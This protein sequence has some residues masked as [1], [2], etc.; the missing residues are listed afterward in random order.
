MTPSAASPEPSKKAVAAQRLSRKVGRIE[1][2]AERKRALDRATAEFLRESALF[3]RSATTPTIFTEPPSPVVLDTIQVR[4][5]VTW[6]ATER[7]RHSPKTPGSR[8]WMPAPS[9]KTPT[10]WTPKAPAACPVAVPLSPLMP[11]TA[12]PA[13][14]SRVLG[15]LPIPGVPLKALPLAI[16][17]LP[18][19]LIV[20][21]YQRSRPAP[22]AC[23]PRLFCIPSPPASAS[24]GPVRLVA[25][26]V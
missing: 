18:Q 16:W 23:D 3:R 5:S 10:A 11:V 1:R 9:P 17:Q 6:D 22:S 8:V 12:V 13:Q 20:S 4:S 25:G 14:A 26:C 21:Q 2:Q 24:A 19:G 7:A 15:S